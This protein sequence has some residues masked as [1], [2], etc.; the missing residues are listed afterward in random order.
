M[1]ACE[2]PRYRLVIE[3]DHTGYS[4]T[5]MD[6]GIAIRT[7][8]GFIDY[9]LAQQFGQRAIYCLNRAET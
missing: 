5:I 7:S 6:D 9:D 3:I 8:G 1:V 4:Y 2:M